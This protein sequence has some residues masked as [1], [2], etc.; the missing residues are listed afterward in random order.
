MA[1][2][3]RA[4]GL[5]VGDNGTHDTGRAA[6][7]A[8]DTPASAF[9]VG[10]GS[11]VAYATV[12]VDS[13]TLDTTRVTKHRAVRVLETPMTYFSL[14]TGLIA[15]PRDL[16]LHFEWAELTMASLTSQASIRT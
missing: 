7:A 9:E 14:S 3:A 15:A 1:A 16:Q 10:A 8:D 11:E 6:L 4:G 2:P 13:S 5:T 12:A